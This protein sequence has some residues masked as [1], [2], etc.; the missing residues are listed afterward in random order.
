MAEYINNDGLRIRFDVD[1]IN[2][3]APRGEAPGAGEDRVI[4]VIVDLSKSAKGRVEGVNI[5]RNSFIAEVVHTTVETTDATAVDLGTLSYDGQTV[6]K[7]SILKAADPSTLGL[8]NV[9]V[10]GDATA[11]DLVGTITETPSHLT[12]EATGATKGVIALRVHIFVAG[13]DKNPG[14]FN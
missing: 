2:Q 5:P 4:D 10:A 12:Y 6:E 14:K 8:R 7:D 9:V 11:G 1:R 13:K 3:G